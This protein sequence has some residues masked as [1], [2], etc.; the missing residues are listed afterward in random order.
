VNKIYNNHET[1]TNTNTSVNNK[2]Q[3]VQIIS[4]IDWEECLPLWIPSKSIASILVGKATAGSSTPFLR[5]GRGETTP[6]CLCGPCYR[7]ALNHG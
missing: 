1:R 5:T 2:H 7:F 6:D 3:H 4:S